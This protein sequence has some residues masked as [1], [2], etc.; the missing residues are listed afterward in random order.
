VASKSRVTK[1]T[2]EEAEI[3]CLVGNGK[4]RE[5]VWQDST[6]KVVRY[7]LTFIN[8]LMYGGDNGRVLGYDVAHGYHH[9]H[10]MGQV[11]EIE[12]RGY[13]NLSERFFREVATLRKKGRL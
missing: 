8:H 2:D 6:G 1:T 7:N 12:F 9:R 11:E 4:L 3:S 10:F 5:E 13:E